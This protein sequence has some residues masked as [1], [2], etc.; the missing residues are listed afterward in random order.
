MVDGAF[1]LVLQCSLK[2]SLSKKGGVDSNESPEYLIKLLQTVLL[3][4]IVAV[5]SYVPFIGHAA[6]ILL[7]AN[8]FI[9]PL[10]IF[11]RD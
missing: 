7:F 8:S 4:V 1:S 2:S 9:N 3:L 5:I 11:Y 6:Y 10:I